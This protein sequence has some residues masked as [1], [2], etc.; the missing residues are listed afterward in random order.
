MK[1]LEFRKGYESTITRRVRL[2]SFGVAAETNGIR[3][4]K[5]PFALQDFKQSADTAVKV[6]KTAVRLATAELKETST[7]AEAIAGTPVEAK[8]GGRKARGK[9]AVQ[10]AS[11]DKSS[12]EV[13]LPIAGTL[14]VCAVEMPIL[15]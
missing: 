3:V 10:S 14:D 9:N 13:T 12:E 8:G 7:G 1:G 6:M 11:L 2:S 5:L 4:V 15:G